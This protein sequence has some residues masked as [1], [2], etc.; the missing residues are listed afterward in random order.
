MTPLIQITLEL[1]FGSCAVVFGG[2]FILKFVEKAL[3]AEAKANPNQNKGIVKNHE[4][5][6]MTTS[7][8]YS[9]NTNNIWN[10]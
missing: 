8:I 10:S 5:T 1:F 9:M 7:P 2:Y 6:D 3:E 4:F